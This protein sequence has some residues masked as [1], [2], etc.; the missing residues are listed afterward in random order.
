MYSWGV[1]VRK[2]SNEL[3]KSEDMGSN[4]RVFQNIYDA[5]QTSHSLIKP[6]FDHLRNGLKNY[7]SATNYSFI[8]EKVSELVKNKNKSV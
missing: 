4:L 8:K 1:R 3:N 6:Q 5:R 2:P 7:P